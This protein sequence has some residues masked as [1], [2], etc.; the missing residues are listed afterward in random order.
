MDLRFDNVTFSDWLT[1]KAE[2]LLSKKIKLDISKKEGEITTL[3]GKLNGMVTEE[4]TDNSRLVKEREFKKIF[5]KHL[6][7]LSVKGLRNNRYL[8]LYSIS[9]F[10]SQGVELHKTVM[11]YHFA[12][13]ELIS[14]TKGIHRFPFMLDAILKED[15]EQ[16]NLKSILDFVSKNAPKNVQTFFTIA[17]S[18]VKNDD[19]SVKYVDID[20]LKNEYF[21]ENSKI[22]RIG[23]SKTERSFLT[24][25]EEAHFDIIAS[26]HDIISYG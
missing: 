2:V 5:I 14:R 8:D 20:K 19:D 22:I 15:I 13:N 9:S 25:I 17:E 23:Q 6:N 12:F 4:E 16:V 11:A 26:T 24:K 21:P 7:S 1:N 3:N 18:K 10:P